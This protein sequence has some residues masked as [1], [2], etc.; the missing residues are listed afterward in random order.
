MITAGGPHITYDEPDHSVVQVYADGAPLVRIRADGD[1]WLL[2]HPREDFRFPTVEHALASVRCQVDLMAQRD[3]PSI[4]P[5][6]VPLTKEHIH[7]DVFVIRRGTTIVAYVEKLPYGGRWTIYDAHRRP[8]VHHR[9]RLAYHYLGA[10][11]EYIVCNL[12]TFLQLAAADPL[13]VGRSPSTH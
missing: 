10:A 2:P 3:L 8:F 5:D 13:T 9:R 7:G 6:F 11:T 1:Q 4:Y 12:P